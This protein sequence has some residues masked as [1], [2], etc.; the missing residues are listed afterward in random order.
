MK[1]QRCDAD[2]LEAVPVQLCHDCAE[3]LHATFEAERLLSRAAEALRGWDTEAAK[4]D[5]LHALSILRYGRATCGRCPYEG[6]ADV[7][8]RLCNA[9]P[10]HHLKEETA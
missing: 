5:V 8:N 2:C 3:A 1:C 7:C 6:Q 10:P 4:R 9:W